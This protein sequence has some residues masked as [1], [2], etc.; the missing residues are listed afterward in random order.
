MK[1]HIKKDINKVV[2]TGLFIMLGIT[3]CEKSDLLNKQPESQINQANYY[4]LPEHAESALNAIYGETRTVYQV[5]GGIFS[6]V[7]QMLEAPTGTSRTES[8]QNADQNALHGLTYD[9]NT[10]HIA[11]YW[12]NTYRLIAQANW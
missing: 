10:A 4:T 11:S 1:T 2:F 6:G 9:G 8:G 5:V 7:Y 12:N 3:G